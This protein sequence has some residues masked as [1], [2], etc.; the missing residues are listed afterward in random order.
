MQFGRDNIFELLQNVYK[1]DRDVLD[2]SGK[3]PLDYRRQKTAVSASTYSSKYFPS[4]PTTTSPFSF[5]GLEEASERSEQSDGVSLL[6]RSTLPFRRNPHQKNAKGSKG[7]SDDSPS[8]SSVQRS[9]SVLVQRIE[10]HVPDGDTMSVLS[11][12]GSPEV[13]N[14][15]GTLGKRRAKANKSF[16]RKKFGTAGRRKNH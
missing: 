8:S 6:Y 15:G 13:D 11:A 4:S 3:K 14:S 2:W 7:P 9:A 16:L 12:D 5:L 10:H 1:A